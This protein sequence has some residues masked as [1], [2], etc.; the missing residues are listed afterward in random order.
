MSVRGDDVERE[1]DAQADAVLAQTDDVLRRYRTLLAECHAV[2]ADQRAQISALQGSAGRVAQLEK[3]NSDRKRRMVTLEAHNRRMCVEYKKM[4]RQRALDR[5]VIQAWQAALGIAQSDT[6][7]GADEAR[8]PKREVE[9]LSQLQMNANTRAH[10]RANVAACATTPGDE[11]MMSED[12]RGSRI[13]VAPA[14]AHM[15]IKSSPLGLQRTE[16]ENGDSELTQDGE[17]AIRSSPVSAERVEL[18]PADSELTQDGGPLPSSSPHLAMRQLHSSE[19][20]EALSRSQMSQVLVPNSMRTDEIHSSSQAEPL[21]QAGRVPLAEKPIPDR[22]AARRATAVPL[23][24]ELT[25]RE[26]HPSD[27][28]LNEAYS[29]NAKLQQMQELHQLRQKE[30]RRCMHGSECKDCAKFYALL[31]VAHAP[32]QASRHRRVQESQES[33]AGFW[34]TEFP[35]SSGREA[36]ENENR[37]LA[38]SEGRRR[39]AEAL[40]NGRYVFRDAALQARVAEYGRD[41]TSG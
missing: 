18:E 11:P 25:A 2:I 12:R 24:D 4:K 20:D 27:F 19:P 26:W 15:L 31:D 21:S 17:E 6:A 22:S 28:K 3:K 10:T 35:S 39:L 30:A 8:S 38:A 29:G 40:V 7:D 41:L 5:Q 13:E 32:Q 16:F 33:L 37:S 9:G 34:R 14:D 1:L 36:D 23:I